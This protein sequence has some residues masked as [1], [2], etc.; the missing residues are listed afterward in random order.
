LG[1]IAYIEATGDT[2]VLP[3]VDA[4]ID[5]LDGLVGSIGFYIQPD[6]VDSWAL[7][8]YGSTA[9]TALLALINAEYAVRVGGERGPERAQWAKDAGDRIAEIAFRNGGWTFGPDRA[10]LYLYP[11]VAMILLDA[12]LYQ[13]THDATHRERALSA[14]RFIQPLKLADSPTRYASPYS[15]E[16]MGAT[17]NDYSTLSS[18]NYLMLALA[19]LFEITHESEYVDELDSVLD[20]METK[21]YGSW[22]LSDLHT[23]ACPAECDAGRVCVADAC[24]VDRCGHAV[25]H[26]WMDGRPA[27][28]VDPEYVCTG[29]NLQLLYVMWYRQQL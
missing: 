15:A 8:T 10:G 7:R 22:C 19:V 14:Y 2:S 5:Q 16:A 18:H 3:T 29:C 20:T 27:S 12:R 1:L 24:S 13:L 21:L 17:T 23:S 11:N 9:I 4:F 6:L 28:T 25:L 26:H